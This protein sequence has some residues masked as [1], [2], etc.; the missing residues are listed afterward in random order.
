MKVAEESKC[1]I[2]SYENYRFLEIL[3]GKVRRVIPWLLKQNYFY[4][5]FVPLF[6]LIKLNSN[7]NS[8]SITN[9]ESFRRIC[10]FIF[11]LRLN[12]EHKTVKNGHFPVLETLV[13]VHRKLRLSVQKWRNRTGRGNQKNYLT[14]I[15]QH[16]SYD[17]IE[18]TRGWVA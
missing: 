14:K 4:A 16:I 18:G 9:L 7:E 10:S 13:F 11:S 1:F 15:V 2:T 5:Y 12:K 8:E 17:G 3:G 6:L